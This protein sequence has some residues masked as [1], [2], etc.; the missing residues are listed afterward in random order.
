MPPSLYKP[1]QQC[2]LLLLLLLLQGYEGTMPSH[3]PPI[4]ADFKGAASTATSKAT[5]A[6]LVTYANANIW[7][8]DVMVRGGQFFC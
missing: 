2:L 6:Q 5:T 8:A 7:T 1:Q 3:H 4:G